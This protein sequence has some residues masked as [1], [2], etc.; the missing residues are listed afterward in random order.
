MVY[1]EYSIDDTLSSFF[2]KT[3][4]T[5]P[6]CDARAELLVGG[7]ATAIQI[8]GTCSYTVYCG[9]CLEYVVQFRPKSLRLDMNMASLAHQV[10]GSLAPT[11]RFEG[12]T[13]PDAQGEKEPLCVY[14]MGRIK[15]VTHLELIL[16]HGWPENSPENFARRRRL[17]A[18]V[19]R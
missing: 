17:M 12:Q 3:S 14:V 18:D 16:A 2:A 19:A 4:A 8:Q 9:Q 15:G 6:D 13:G 7:K 11:V 10:Y 5:R 1:S